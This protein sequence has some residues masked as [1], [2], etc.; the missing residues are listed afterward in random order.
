[1]ELLELNTLD[2]VYHVALKVEARMKQGKDA[3][4]GGIHASKPTYGKGAM[5]ELK[6]VEEEPLRKGKGL[7]MPLGR[8][9]VLITV[10]GE[11]LHPLEEGV[12]EMLHKAKG[13]EGAQ[14]KPVIKG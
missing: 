12:E 8:K 1:M 4:R 10:R 7:V 2:R 13:P 9:E 3:Q 11:E 5:Q 6:S 14:T